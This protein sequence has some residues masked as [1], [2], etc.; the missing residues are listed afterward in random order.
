MSVLYVAPVRLSCALNA[1][2]IQL[3]KT[4]YNTETGK[5][6]QTGLE[7]ISSVTHTAYYSLLDKGLYPND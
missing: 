4:D 3:Q 2:P 1:I 5:S 6:G 7:R